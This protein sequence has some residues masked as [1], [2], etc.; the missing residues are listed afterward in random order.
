MYLV[1]AT[2]VLEFAKVSERV[3]VSLVG[4]FVFGLQLNF[5]FIMIIFIFYHKFWLNKKVLLFFLIQIYV[6]GD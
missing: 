1:M 3:F 4:S 6:R 5:F 2:I